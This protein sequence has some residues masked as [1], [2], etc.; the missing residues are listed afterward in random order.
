M[1]V[2]KAR[3]V[4]RKR[5]NDYILIIGIRAVFDEVTR[6]GF[7][8]VL[9]TQFNIDGI[10]QSG[11]EIGG[12]GEGLG[13]GVAGFRGRATRQSRDRQRRHRPSKNTGDH[14]PI[15]RMRA[16]RFQGLILSAT[17]GFISSLGILVVTSRCDW[18]NSEKT[19]S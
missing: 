6:L 7:G 12:R 2:M 4:C 18:M 19:P 9:P 1:G 15:L 13:V 10:E 11:S 16:V 8:V 17:T 3:A 5:L 14:S